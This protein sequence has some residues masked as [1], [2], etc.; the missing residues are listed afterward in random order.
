MLYTTEARFVCPHSEQDE[1]QEAEKVP[2][3]P[4]IIDSYRPQTAPK[5][6]QECPGLHLPLT[7]CPQVVAPD[8]LRHPSELMRA[9]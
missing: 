6:R 5:P 1:N 3:N 9:G 2:T 8:L 4:V 7:Q